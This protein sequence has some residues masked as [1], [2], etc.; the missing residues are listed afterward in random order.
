[1][2]KILLAVMIIGLFVMPAKAE[3]WFVEFGTWYVQPDN[4]QVFGRWMDRQDTDFP[5]HDPRAF[6]FDDE[7][8]TLDLEFGYD[9]GEYGVFSFYYWDGYSEDVSY[10]FDNRDFS[11][12]YF[13][14]GGYWDYSYFEAEMDSKLYELK[15]GH[16]LS[17]NDRLSGSYYVGIRYF[18]YELNFWNRNNDENFD[19]L[20]SDYNIK[21]FD[22]EVDGWGFSGGVE[23]QFKFSDMFSLHG[24]IDLAFLRGDKEILYMFREYDNGNLDEGPT[25]NHTYNDEIIPQM[26]L[27]IGGLFTF[28]DMFYGNFG[29]RYSVWQDVATQLP[30][31]SNFG[32][33]EIDSAQDVNWSGFYLNLGLSF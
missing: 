15:W 21:T 12:F 6:E 9:A 23:G 1:M 5:I 29:Y 28:N 13:V 4:S 22:N 7:E 24:G 19:P 17:G 8:F 11:T 10:Q 33:T 2:K 3:G 26:G 14:P 32:E 25:L 20:T 31:F 16:S 30:Q 27:D 18:D